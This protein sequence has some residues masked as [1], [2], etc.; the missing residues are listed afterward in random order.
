MVMPAVVNVNST[1]PVPVLQSATELL[2]AAFHFLERLLKHWWLIH[3][4]P[5]NPGG[6]VTANML[7]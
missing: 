6:K 3:V 7:H 2:R 5:V 1:A 4:G